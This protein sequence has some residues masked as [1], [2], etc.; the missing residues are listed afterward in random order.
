MQ[1]L[2]VNF[3]EKVPTESSHPN[4]RL[5]VGAEGHH[6]LNHQV[7]RENDV[8]GAWESR[9]TETVKN[10]CVGIGVLW[11]LGTGGRVTTER[12]NRFY[13]SRVILALC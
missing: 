9:P 3:V 11:H 12:I 8:R 5:M 6:G 4:K 13:G 2:L 10:V 1:P 7:S